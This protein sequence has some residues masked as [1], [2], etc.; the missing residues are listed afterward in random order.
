[1]LQ[2]S[3]KS[4]LESGKGRGRI[5][6]VFVFGLSVEIGAMLWTV[7]HNLP[8]MMQGT[9]NAFR[10]FGAIAAITGEF[11]AIYTYILLFKVGGGQWLSTFATHT[12]MLT[13]LVFNSIVRYAQLGNGANTNIN[14]V[15]AFYGA[16][17]APLPIFAIALIGALMIV[18]SDPSVKQR[19]A[20]HDIEHERGRQGVAM[21]KWASSQM[22]NYLDSPE[23]HDA[24]KIAAKKTI[25]EESQRV[26][27]E[28][29]GVRFSHNGNHINKT[30]VPPNDESRPN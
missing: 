6:A 10:T 30:A 14:E 20:D 29:L 22:A 15:F 7:S 12:L 8:L 1:M 21:K 13:A 2:E 17:I 27:Q 19:N 25:A 23:V 5:V 26:A 3:V 28:L 11:V 24:L 18:H 16:Y 4:F 9:D